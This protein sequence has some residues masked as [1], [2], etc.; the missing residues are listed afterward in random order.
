MPK[1]G[2]YL[3]EE[4]AV[5]WAG[6]RDRGAV[7]TVAVAGGSGVYTGRDIERWNR[8]GVD[9]RSTALQQRE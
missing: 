3:N 1:Y 6:T 7:D 4:C 8:I 2:T 9:A 5:G